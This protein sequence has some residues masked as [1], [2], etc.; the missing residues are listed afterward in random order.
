MLQDWFAQP[1]TEAEGE[2]IAE[3]HDKAHGRLERRTLRRRRLVPC[4]QITWWNVPGAR[5]GLARDCWARLL[6]SGRERAER[7]YA[8]TSLAPEQ[9]NAAA[10]AALWRGHWTIENRAHHVRDVTCQEEAGQAW[11]GSTPQVVAALRNS[12]LALFRLAG[13]TNMAA[14]FRHVAASVPRAFT[15]LN[16]S[17]SH[18]LRL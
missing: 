16:A 14:A 11:T 6:G 2:E 7:T 18:P 9:A 15:L 3:T 1:A 4:G 5:Q 12:A 10:L 17:P 8:L 13:W